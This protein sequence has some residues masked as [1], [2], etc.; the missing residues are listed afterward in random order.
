MDIAAQE[1]AKHS[2]LWQEALKSLDTGQETELNIPFP[3]K[4]T[5][6]QIA[7]PL[8]NAWT[9]V[10]TEQA[11][12][13]LAKSDV[14]LN[15]AIHPSVASKIPAEIFRPYASDATKNPSEI[16][17]A[18]VVKGGALLASIGGAGISLIL[19]SLRS[20]SDPV[21][22]PIMLTVGCVLTGLSAGGIGGYL[23]SKQYSVKVDALG[24]GVGLTAP[25][26]RASA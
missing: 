24:V 26:T 10:W 11:M 7:S 1:A 25:P 13:K 2:R 23:V 20:T 5:I 12:D 3:A 4:Q 17:T 15:I 22:G 6:R 16:P 19:Q 14:R 21:L 9:N 8:S 18:D